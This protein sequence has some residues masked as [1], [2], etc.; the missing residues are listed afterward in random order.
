MT[1]RLKLQ[2]R[3]KFVMSNFYYYLLPLLLG[4]ILFG[5]FIFLKSYTL[6][7]SE[8][9][10]YFIEYHQQLNY[11]K[12]NRDYDS[13]ELFTCGQR[14]RD[15]KLSTINNEE[16]NLS[17]II[18]GSS[19][20]YRFSEFSCTYCVENDINNL[21]TIAEMEHLD[22]HIIILS[23]HKN[24]K[25]MKIFR[26]YHDLQ[27]AIFNAA[28][29]IELPIEPDTLVENPYFITLEKDLTIRFVHAS[30]PSD[31]YDHPFFKRVSNYL[32]NGE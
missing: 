15:I 27:F 32:I 12:I 7:L 21:K 11:I 9:N 29:P 28:A 26:E 20:I 13:L 30:D 3:S 19:L 18:K 10:M 5:A 23:Q 25:Y 22:N 4:G 1:K 6:L 24:I 14:I 2:I 17:D 16:V 31:Q 8:R